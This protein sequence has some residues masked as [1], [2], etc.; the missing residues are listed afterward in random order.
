MRAMRKNDGATARQQKQK[1]ERERERKKETPG[2][3]CEKMSEPE[4]P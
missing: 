2:P 1:R 3:L 4:A